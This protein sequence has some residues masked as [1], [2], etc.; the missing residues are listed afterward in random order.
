MWVTTRREFV[1]LGTRDPGFAYQ[2]SSQRGVGLKDSGVEE[3]ND[4]EDFLTF[5]FYMEPS[6]LRLPYKF[7]S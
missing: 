5:Y 4:G 1:F 3:K 6:V 7:S 2:D